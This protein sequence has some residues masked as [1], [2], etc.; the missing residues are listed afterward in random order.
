MCTTRLSCVTLFDYG[1]AF[2]QGAPQDKPTMNVR[3]FTQPES[4]EQ[5][6]TGFTVITTG[7]DV[8]T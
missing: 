6:L 3:I 1:C 7:D 5:V 8:I 4:L 2:V